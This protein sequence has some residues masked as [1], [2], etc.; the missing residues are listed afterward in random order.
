[1]TNTNPPAEISGAVV[2]RHELLAEG[3]TDNQI[4]RL[5]RRGELHRVRHG[6]YVSGALWAGLSP[7][8]RH[9]LLIRAVLKRAH[10]SAVATHI[11]SAVEH[12]APVWG[13]SLDEV[14]ITRTDGRTGRREAGVV[15]HRGQLD[16]E[17]MELV[18]GIPVS[19]PPRCAVE[20]TTMTTVEPALVTVNWM[21]HMKLLTPEDFA[22]AVEALKHW[23]DTLATTIVLRLCDPRIQSVGE[24]RTSFMCWDQHLPRPEPQVPVYDEF[25]TLFAYVDFAWR[26]PGVF[27]EFDG[28]IK[29]E[30]F[31]RDGETLEAFLMREK[32][33]EERICQLTGWVC[34]RI[35]WADL[36]YPE[37][38]ARRI[39]SILD[40]RRR[41]V[42]A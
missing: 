4:Q 40:A 14:H 15:H 42:G 20:V 13:I 12:G 37:R 26:E 41:P 33:R 19:R 29:Y 36:S 16:P 23:P 25:G 30:M 3:Y 24:S 31:R 7:P 2:L 6:S 39:R 8:D 11:S 28:R 32:H 35:T 9:R 34:V 27:L 5:V 1:M 38:T 21:L 18:N 17:D 22:A 10:P